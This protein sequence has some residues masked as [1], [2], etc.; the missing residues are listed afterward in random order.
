MGLAAEARQKSTVSLLEPV[1]CERQSGK[2]LGATAAAPVLWL[3]SQ[4]QGTAVGSRGD[5]ASL[6]AGSE[7][8]P[9]R[10]CWIGNAM[11]PTC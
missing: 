10:L 6:P 7:K 1:T 8:D 5:D 9:E 11:Q 2:R 4:G 3:M